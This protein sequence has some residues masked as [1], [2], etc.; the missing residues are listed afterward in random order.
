MKRPL[1]LL[2][3]LALALPALAQDPATN[4]AA[5]DLGELARQG[6]F[7]RIIGDVAIEWRDARITDV[8]E[9]L[10]DVS[11]SQMYMEHGAT[12]AGIPF[13]V[14]P[15]A[16]ENSFRT[17]EEPRVSFAVAEG[18]DDRLFSPADLAKLAAEAAGMYLSI[19]PDCVIIHGPYE[20]GTL[21]QR[22]F[23]P[24]AGFRAAVACEPFDGDPANEGARL[25]AFFAA[26]GV[27]WSDGSL[28]EPIPSN[29]W[30]FLKVI[31]TSEHQNRIGEI[32]AAP[33]FSVRKVS[34]RARLLA[35]EGGR[36]PGG[37]PDLPRP[38][39]RLLVRRIPA[40]KVAAVAAEVADARGAVVRDLG[41]FPGENG[42]ATR[43]DSRPPWRRTSGGG[44]Y[45]L[46][47]EFS[48][49]PDHPDSEDGCEP[50]NES[51][52]MVLPVWNGIRGWKPD[53]R[54][55]GVT[56]EATPRFSS[57]GAAIS[58]HYVLRSLSETPAGS[59][60]PLAP[61]HGCAGDIDLAPGDALLLGTLRAPVRPG[62]P[63][64]ALALLLE[65]A[66]ATPS[67]AEETHAESAE[68]A[69]PEPHAESA[70][71]AE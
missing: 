28:V 17:N 24:P 53:E 5:A 7:E 35:F 58:L 2:P 39:R 25:R 32:L 27:E 59:A 43:W 34:L 50:K 66:P 67:P 70:E 65:T 62:E 21:V 20:E 57:D 47:W 71:F 30:A 41:A 63:P 37:L 38:D 6:L 52:R 51:W 49:E 56:L 13:L 44:F 23:E 48:A 12:N 68:N 19:R 1:L 69:E 55:A 60:T 18:A 29:E 4:A 26:R 22:H 64:R 3:L 54:A 15:Y 36:A 61:P 40:A 14:G 33:G 8:A 31:Q 46:P 16:G 42:L 11:R 45:D 9:F 10:G